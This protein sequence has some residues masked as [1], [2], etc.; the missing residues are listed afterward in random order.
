M[1]T[2][3]L[4]AGVARLGRSLL[5]GAGVGQG[6]D[7]TFTDF[8]TATGEPAGLPVQLRGVP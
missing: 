2:L 1:F 8:D 5:Q 3:L 4:H 7:S 6:C